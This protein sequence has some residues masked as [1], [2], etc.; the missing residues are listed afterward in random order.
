MVGAVKKST[1]YLNAGLVIFAAP[2]VAVLG[3][4]V[5]EIYQTDPGLIWVMAVCGLWF[6]AIGF[7]MSQHEYWK[8]KEW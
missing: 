7:C 2:V 6:S 3:W 5:H 8:R 1:L 4:K